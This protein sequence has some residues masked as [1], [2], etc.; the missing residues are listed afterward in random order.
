[1]PNKPIFH[2]VVRENWYATQFGRSVE[3]RD[4][5]TERRIQTFEPPHAWGKDWGWNISPDGKGIVFTHN[6]L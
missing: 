3:I 5:S 6:V 1:M 2:A 4:K